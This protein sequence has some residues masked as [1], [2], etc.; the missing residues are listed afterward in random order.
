MTMVNFSDIVL[1]ILKIST[2]HRIYVD[3]VNE[4]VEQLQY[5]FK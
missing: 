1:R 4:Y 2:S 5:I 3:T